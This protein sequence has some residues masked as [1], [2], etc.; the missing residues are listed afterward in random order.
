VAE[1]A[2]SSSSQSRKFRADRLQGGVSRPRK[3][4]QSEDSAELENLSGGGNLKIEQK[5]VFQQGLQRIGHAAL[6]PA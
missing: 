3:A 5:G 6:A 2:I 4:P 1:K